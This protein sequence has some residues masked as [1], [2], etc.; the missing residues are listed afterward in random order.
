MTQKVFEASDGITL[1]YRDLGP[2]DGPTVVLCHGL[3][4]QGLQFGEDAEYFA[5]LN[6]R[7][8][9]P[10]V[11]GHGQS[12]FPPDYDP[13][14]FSVPVLAA[15][16]LAML[17][18]A[19]AG[20]VHWVGNSL[21]GI[22]ALEMVGIVPERFTTLTIFGTA[23]SLDLPAVSGP[24]LVVLYRMFGPDLVSRI[25]AVGTTRERSARPL[26]AQM[27]AEFDPEVGKAIASH[28]RRYDLTANA[29]A[30]PGPMLII[31]GGR[32]NAVNLVLRPALERIGPRPNWTVIDLPEGSHVA[33]LDATAQWRQALLDFWAANPPGAAA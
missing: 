26:V 33:N 19:G 14:A 13:A 7:V 32:D 4:A 17:D 28:V 5:S 21:G 10:D 24:A 18:H 1:A 29:L 6:Y 9:V 3:G 25:S 15:D 23:F 31:V 22:V 12:G 30:Y 2:A 20:Q 11:R 8:L 16:M 27:L